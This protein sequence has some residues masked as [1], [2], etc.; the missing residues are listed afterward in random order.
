MESLCVERAGVR[1]GAPEQFTSAKCEKPALM[2]SAEAAA[3]MPK[4]MGPESSL[5]PSTPGC[6]E[7]RS[8]PGVALQACARTG[9]DRAVDRIPR[10]G[11]EP[12][13]RARARGQRQHRLRWVAT[14]PDDLMASRSREPHRSGRSTHRGVVRQRYL[15][16]R[17]AVLHFTREEQAALG[18][19]HGERGAKHVGFVS[20]DAGPDRPQSH[21]RTRRSLRCPEAALCGSKPRRCS[22]NGASC[23][24]E[25][26]GVRPPTRTSRAWMRRK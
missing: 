26:C 22:L 21:R 5:A 11:V 18:V 19:A 1:G 10:N 17:R 4:T 2:A 14:A 16:L 8:P 3:P 7:V 13:L 12:R 6:A 15:R 20:C 24:G 23:Q 25:P 9:P